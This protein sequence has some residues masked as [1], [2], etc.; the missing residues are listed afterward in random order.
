VYFFAHLDCELCEYLSQRKIFRTNLAKR[1]ETR[2]LCLVHFPLSPT[3]FEI[4]K[5]NGAGA[6]QGL[7]YVVLLRTSLIAKRGRRIWFHCV[8]NPSADMEFPLL[9]RRVLESTCV[10]STAQLHCLRSPT[11]HS[12]DI[13]IHNTTTYRFEACSTSTKCLQIQFL[14]HRKHTSSIHFEDQSSMLFRD[15]NRC[16]L[17]ES[18]ETNAEFLWY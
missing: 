12:S 6:T 3:D 7:V 10:R 15:I 1:H 4:I 5:L 8:G 9:L 13:W 2:M 18:Y 17:W 16:L 11:Y 14:P